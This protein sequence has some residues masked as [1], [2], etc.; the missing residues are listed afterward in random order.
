[1]YISL[2]TVVLNSRD[3]GKLWLPKK[4]ALKNNLKTI[5]SPKTVHK[6]IGTTLQSLKIDSKLKDMSGVGYRISKISKTAFCLPDCWPAVRPTSA[7]RTG[8]ILSI[9]KEFEVCNIDLLFEENL[10]TAT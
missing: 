9:I 2:S 8:P 3:W 6:Y 5:L 4:R 1:M 7:R 10:S